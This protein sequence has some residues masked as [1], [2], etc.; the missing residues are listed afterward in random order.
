MGEKH[1]GPVFISHSSAD[2][3]VALEICSEI[4]LRGVRCAIAPRDVPMGSNWPN[5]IVETI[6]KSSAFVLII[7][8]QANNSQAV[9][10]ETELAYNNNG[11]RIYPVRIDAIEKSELSPG[12][13]LFI[14]SVQ[15][16]DAI[17][18]IRASALDR[19]GKTIARDVL[20]RQWEAKGPEQRK[21]NDSLFFERLWARMDRERRSVG[22]LWEAA[23]GGPLWSFYRGLNRL[24]YTLSAMLALLVLFAGLTW[25][26]NAA[27]LVLL[28]GWFG[29]ATRLALLGAMLLRRHVPSRGR[30]VEPQGTAAVPA[31][32]SVAMLL[33]AL[34]ISSLIGKNGQEAR[35][36]GSPTLKLRRPTDPRTVLQRGDRRGR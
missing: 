33:A 3:T 21:G 35:A 10:K 34:S 5:W 18:P 13:R 7:S 27:S 30:Q 32:V 6:E 8:H 22:W 4:E 9:Q 20:G 17:R 24:G 23:L 1:L 16:F 19:L 15:M 2:S 26:I 12:L 14:S 11:M 36:S 28:L 25:S 31:M 29:I